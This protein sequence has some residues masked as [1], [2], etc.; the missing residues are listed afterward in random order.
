MHCFIIGHFARIMLVQIIVFCKCSMSARYRLRA[1]GTVAKCC[2]RWHARKGCILRF[3]SRDRLHARQAAQQGAPRLSRIVRGA[4]AGRHQFYLGCY[5]T[6][7]TTA[8]GHCPV[9][10][11]TDVEASLLCEGINQT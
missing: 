8:A 9:G 3:T 6:C 5:A 1:A 7:R 2:R 11:G 10:H 4:Q